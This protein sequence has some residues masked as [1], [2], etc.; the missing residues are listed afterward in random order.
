MKYIKPFLFVMLSVSLSLYLAAGSAG[1][2]PSSADAGGDEAMM[3]MA[4]NPDNTD[5]ASLWKEVDD[6]ESKGLPKSALEAVKKIYDLAKKNRNAGEFTKA[7][8]HKLYFL[9]QV[10]EEAFV[11][12][13]IALSEEIKQSEFPIT[14]VLHSMLAQ[15]YWGYYQTHRYRFLDRTQTAPG[16][17]QDDIRTWDLRKIVEAVVFHYGQSLENPEKL[18]KINVNVFDKVIYKGNRPRTLRPTLYD[19]LAH[20]AI[21]FYMSGEAG[22]TAPKYQ[23]TLNDKKYF[24]PTQ[25]FAKLE[26]TTRDALSFEYHALVYLQDLVKFHLGDKAPDALVDVDLK[27]LHFVYEKAVISNKELVYEE[28][29]QRMLDKYEDSPAAAG[30][31][32]ELAVLYDG[33]G[34][35]YK[36]AYSDDYK[37]HKKKAH[38]LCREAIEKYPD[39][40][41]AHNCQGLIHAIEAR[42]LQLTLEHAVVAHSPSRALLGYRNFDKVY[43]KIVQTGIDEVQQ[44]KRMRRDDMVKRFLAKPAVKHWTVKLPIDGDFQPHSVEIKLDGLAHGQYMLLASDSENFDFQNHAVAYSFFMVSNISYIHRNRNDKDTGWEFYLVDRDSGRPLPGARALAWFQRYNHTARRYERI[45]GKRF[46]ADKNGY[47]NIPPGSLAQNYF[48]LEFINGKDRL[49]L[50]RAL[51]LY[52]PYDHYKTHVKTIFFT[53]RAIYRPGQT[54]YFKGIVLMIDPAAP[55][56]NKIMP[57]HGTR[58]TL[59]DVNRQ[60]VGDLDLVT[61]EYGTFSG[62]FQLPTGRLNGNMRIADA[63]GG[64]D[65]SMEEY[66]RPKFQV[67]F[68]PLEKSVRLD[69]TVTVTGEAKAY[70]GYAVDNADVKY[71]VVRSVY[72]PYPWYCY[73]RYGGFYPL[74]ASTMEIANGTAVT[75]ADGSFEITFDA[76]PDLMI[77][78]NTRPAFIFTVYADVTDINGETQGS[79]KKI[80]V[81]YTAL[82]LD[83]NLPETL[84]KEDSRYKTTINSTTLSGEFVP[85]EGYITIHKLKEPDRVLRKRPWNK[86]DKFIIA[87]KE[88]H[89]LFP[90]DVYKDEDEV[91]KWEKGKQTYR[92]AFDTSEV[93]EIKLTGLGKWPTGKYV[94]EMKSKDRFGND[95]E[96]VRYFTLFSSSGKKTPYTMGHW[97][98][99]LKNQAEPG[100][101]AVILIGS[102]EKNVHL[103]YQVE[104]RGS[105]VDTRYIT[106]DNNQRRIELPIQEKHRGSVGIHL[107]AVRHNRPALHSQNIIVPWSNKNLDISFGTFRDKLAPGEKETWQIKIKGPKGDQAAAEMVAALYDAS[108]DAFRANHW[109]FSIFTNYYTRFNWQDNPYFGTIGSSL[110]GKLKVPYG[111]TQHRY[112]SLEWFG[113]YPIEADWGF[114]RGVRPAP[115]GA[116]APMRQAAL[117]TEEIEEEVMRDEAAPQSDKFE[118]AKAK[119]VGA[120]KKRNG[121]KEPPPTGDEPAEAAEAPVQVRTNFNETAFFYPHLNTNPEGEVVISFTVPEALTRWKMMGFAHAKNLEYGFVNNYLVTQKDLMV[122]PNPPRFFREGD[123]L[124]FT[125]KITNLSDKELTGTASLQLLDAVTMRPKDGEFENRAPKQAF[126]VKKGQSDSVQWRL[127]IPRGMDAVTYRV[128]ARAGQFSDGEENTIPILKNRMLVTESLPLPVRSRQTKTFTFDKLLKSAS[129]STIGHHRLTLEFTSNPVWYAVQALPYLMEY[130]HECIEQ[131]FSRYYANSMASYIV[132]ANPKIKRVFD[133]WKTQMGVEGSPNANALLSNLEKNQELKAVLLEETPWVRNGQN[134]TQRKKRIALLFDLN[135]MAAQ[136]ERALKKLEEGQLPSGGWPWFKGMRES[137]YITQHI[138]CGFAHLDALNV[139][140]ARQD[141]R[142][143]KMLNQAVSYLDVQLAEDYRQLLQ[144]DIDLNK[145][146]LGFL[147][148][149]YFYARGYFQDIPLDS[150]DRT[151]FDYYKGQIKKYWTDFN[152][153]KYLQGMMA[154]IMK[155]YEEAETAVAIAESIKEHALYSE[156]M[157]MYWRSQWGYYWYQAPIETQ[158]LLIEVFGEVLNDAKSVDEMKTWLL[159]Q[160]QTQDWRTT[161]ATAEACYALLLRGEDWLKESRPPE[162]T[163][164]KENPITI[165]PGETG[166]GAGSEDI[167]R[168]EAGTG[169]FKTSW[170]GG[171]IQPG[172][173]V[174]KVKN[175]NNVAAWGSLYWQ[176]FENLDKITP[177]KTPLHLEKKLFVEKPSDTGPVLHPIEAG[178]SIK[179]GDRVKVRIE[180]R[181]D[182]D[183][184]YIHMKDMRASSFEPEN[185]ISSYHWQDG[186]GYYQSTKDASTNFFIDYLPKGTYVFEYGLRVTHDG[187]FSNGITQIQCMYAP[188]F[189]SHSEG[190]R[191]K[192]GI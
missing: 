9:Q 69:D 191:V 52:R 136:L 132:N 16:F 42:K 49:F 157:G 190:V 111:Y 53:D 50:D 116:R 164:G 85:A 143:W 32:Y 10:E 110:I 36:P 66:K 130:P 34:N 28:T 108:L 3:G 67:T 58:V 26:I 150:R 56:K 62:V 89:Q 168:A 137:R 175:N 189:T 65:F 8:I 123:T 74:D 178:S 39:T 87:E 44:T 80:N 29:L 184:E 122:V 113:Y 144:H 140:D 126:T 92:A 154:L 133:I 61:N 71:R 159:K 177:A 48:F 19:F 77:D 5:Y 18:K 142:T 75:G 94:L 179:I 169:Y 173:A 57:N 182:R 86:P 151:A 73:Y 160:K 54:V 118:L 13:P 161:K 135:T 12:I 33:L 186:L 172:M 1:C 120:K 24:S 107:A 64:I 127:R 187:D 78:K 141:K 63:N 88:F 31:Y 98:A 51:G 105:I 23:F 115:A 121:E 27:R 21:D 119:S 17:K 38:D 100:E 134:E 82:K 59:Y 147:H 37:W 162:I 2:S 84:D 30:I 46:T 149:H 81:G 188:E 22:L 148:V 128:I 125:S 183:M 6:F 180:L 114:D 101:K 4:N 165:I 170:T 35:K 47:F 138:V 99:V 93:K 166:P 131:I 76:V 174:V 167:I 104:H 139:I 45:E 192:V 171:D 25:T 97:Y 103:I 40:G 156:E 146:N 90:Y 14:P 181:V 11:K 112:D 185:V 55:E 124:V 70:A 60:K 176:Y 152:N 20:R 163:I 41:G 129:S 7:V 91:H 15:Q 109:G 117:A 68:K 155:R 145:N 79:L 102:S 158:A 153:S 72:F 83:V 96:E 43:L 106:L 95:V